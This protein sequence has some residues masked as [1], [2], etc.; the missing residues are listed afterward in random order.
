[1]VP[2]ITIMTMTMITIT[3]V[4]ITE[5]GA[6][7]VEQ[8]ILVRLIKTI[9]YHKVVS[10]PKTVPKILPTE[11][12]EILSQSHTTKILAKVK[13]NPKPLLF[14]TLLHEQ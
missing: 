11:S 4:A 7:S 8:K 6:G 3:T 5:D 13:S 2:G 10:Q 9:K 14:I 12:S 1:V